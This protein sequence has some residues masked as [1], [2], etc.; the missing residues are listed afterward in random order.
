MRSSKSIFRLFLLVVLAAFGVVV[1]S[2]CESSNSSDGGGATLEISAVTA[3]PS[4]ISLS[5]Q[6][7]IEATVSDNDG[8]PIANRIVTFSVSTSYGTVTPQIDTTD[9]EG[10]A[11]TVFS[12]TQSGSAVVTARISDEI[13]RSVTVE[14]EGDDSPQFGTG[15][16]EVSISPELI[17]A[18]SDS[19][20]E[21][22]VTVTDADGVAAPESTMV[23]FAAGEKFADIDNNGYFTTGVDSVIYDVIDNNEW[24]AI[25]NIPST[26]VTDASGQATVTYTAGMQAMTVYIKATCLV[27]GY[28]GYAETTVQLTPDAQINSIYLASDSIHLAVKRTGGLETSTLRAIG[29][30]VNGN[31]VPEGLAVNFIITDGPDTTLDG[32][33]LAD[34]TG[35]DRRGP[36]TATTN[37][38]GVASCPI[39]SG[40]VSGTIRIRAYADTILSN[41]TQIMVHAGPPANIVVGVEECNV[42]WWDK[43]NEQMGVTAL[44]SDVYNN[45]CSDSTVVYFT[46]DEGVIMAHQARTQD[47][48]GLAYSTWISAGNDDTT[49][50]GD[51]WVYA[52]TEG[53]NVLDSAMF[54]NS[55]YPSTITWTSYP[56]SLTADGKAKGYGHVEV[57]D[58]NDNFVNDLAN[59]KLEA[60]YASFIERENGDGCFSSAVSFRVQSATLDMDYSLTGG[61]DDGVGAVDYLTARYAS[62]ASATVPCTLKTGTAYRDNCELSAEVTNVDYG[63]TVYFSVSIADRWG[64]PLGD[65]TL[66]ATATNGAVIPSGTK[67][68]DAYGAAEGYS[69]TAPGEASGVDGFVVTVQDIDARGGIILT[70]EFTIPVL[71]ILN[72][73]PTTL[74][75]GDAATDLPFAISNSG[76]GTINWTIMPDQTWLSVDINSGTTIQEVDNITASVDRTGLAAGDYTGVITVSSDAGNFGIN[77]SMTVP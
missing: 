66:V 43:V 54:I 19:T 63:E 21:V 26:A 58:L 39:S 35:D 31:R 34:L 52:E 18:S 47:E 59:I 64:N 1:L 7:V 40:T 44:V 70:K 8:S 65:H 12:P 36:Y 48:M 51:V 27:A 41:A 15:Q 11:A 60:E 67:E 69:V 20:A 75:F 49:A 68:T 53:G 3:N 2:G 55:Y 77:V 32:E 37:S 61:D 16:L 29:Y 42:T 30:D 14:I 45:P 4:S 57:R 24:D 46:C 50:D 17:L 72:V 62:F 73:T 10:L 9:A 6:C 71:P 22:T 23:R 33:H 28:D 25:G 5:Q 56:A 76:N 13:Y 38:M 74:S